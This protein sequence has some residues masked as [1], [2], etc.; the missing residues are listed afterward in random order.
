MS[1]VRI[2]SKPGRVKPHRLGP[3]LTVSLPARVEAGPSEAVGPYKVTLEIDMV[4]G[5]IG[6]TEITVRTASGAPVTGTD[7][8]AIPVG[9]IVRLATTTLVQETIGRNGDFVTVTPYQPPEIN[10]R[11]GATDEA[12]RF[13]AASYSLAYALGEPPAKAVER[14]LGIA[15]STASKWIKLARERGYLDIPA[16]KGQ[17][18]KD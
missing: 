14:D 2:T 7:L 6:C 10:V 16:G 15:T 8:R 13:V 1:A 12:L 3:D 5:R 4:D 17:K 11:A 18:G 9:T